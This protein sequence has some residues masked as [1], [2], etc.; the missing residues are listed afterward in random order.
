MNQASASFRSIEIRRMPG[1]QRGELALPDLCAG[2][3]VIY[4]PNASG[5]TT[6]CRAIHRLLRPTDPGGGDV[7]LRASFELDGA[8]LELD[9]DLGRMRAT[10]RADGASID[11]PRLAPPEIGDRHVLALQD[12]IRTEHDRD[13]ARQIVKELSGGYDVGAARRQLDFRRQ[14][15]RRG[16]LTAALQQAERRHQA[17]LRRQDELLERQTQ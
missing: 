15:T 8:G 1:F 14:P 13:L 2:I 4:G 9:Y 10:R 5:K 12:L 17:A 11:Y 3:N 7:S 6:L 16:K